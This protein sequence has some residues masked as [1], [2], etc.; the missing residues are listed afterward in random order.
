MAYCTPEVPEILRGDAA[1]IR[2]I[3]LN[4]A[5][6]A[7]KFTESGEVAIMVKVEQVDGHDGGVLFEVSDTG[8]GIAAADQQR[9]S[10]SFSQADASTTRKYGGS[11]LGLAISQRLVEGMGGQIGVDS[12]G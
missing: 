11:G 2:Q 7:V 3:R 10:E 1:R 5:G 6:N 9:L 8:I 4:L 12:C